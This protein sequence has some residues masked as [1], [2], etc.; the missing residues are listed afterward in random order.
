[1]IITANRLDKKYYG[2]IWAGLILASY[3]RCAYQL[4]DVFSAMDS[5]AVAQRVMYSILYLLSY[6]PLPAWL[7]YCCASIFWGMAARRGNRFSS[8]KDFIYITM[9]FTMVARVVMGMVEIFALIEPLVFT[10]TSILLDVTVLSTALYVMY[11]TVFVKNYMNPKQAYEA[12]SLYSMIYLVFQGI[13][14]GLPC[15]AYFLASGETEFSQLF[16]GAV[17]SYGLSFSTSTHSVIACGLGLGVL[18]VF[19]I[20]TSVLTMVLKKRAAGYVPPP[21]KPPT[22]GMGVP[23]EEM[24]PDKPDKVFEEFD[25]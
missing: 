17:N 15:L 4:V 8:Q 3:F 22:G 25:I 12:F 13:H 14:T 7:C 24:M 18:G 5:L 21:P 20:V 1:M 2:W 9:L 23:F 11:F 19:I 16:L 6:G 10:Y